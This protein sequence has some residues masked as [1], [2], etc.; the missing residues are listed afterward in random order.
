MINLRTIRDYLGLNQDEMAEVLHISRSMVAKL[1]SGKHELTPRTTSILVSYLRDNNLVLNDSGEIV[2]FISERDNT[3]KI[4]NLQDQLIESQ[5]VRIRHLEQLVG[6]KLLML[7]AY[8][9]VGLVEMSR[10]SAKVNSQT[11]Q[12]VSRRLA[13]ALRVELQKIQQ[14]TLRHYSLAKGF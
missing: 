8:A 9:K 3:H 7:E 11:E 6:D 13:E 1:E 2:P 4:Q 10:V 5:L 14:E 12:D